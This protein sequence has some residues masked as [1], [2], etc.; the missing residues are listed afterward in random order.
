MRQKTDS[1]DPFPGDGEMSR[2]M[3]AHDWSATP[4]GPVASWPQSLKIAVCILLNSRYAMWLGWGPEFTFFY[5]DAYARMTL[6]A[7]HP[8]ALGRPAREVWPEIW[9]DVGPRAESVVRTG[10]A[11]WDER[12]LLFLE[13]RGFPEETY[14]TFSY[15]RVPDDC[16]GVGG[17]L[18]V[19]TEDTERTIGERR[20]RTLREL[21][22]RTTEEARSV[23]DACQ[24]AA[25]ILADNPH[26]LPFIL[27][28][29]IDADTRTARLAGVTGLP[30]R[31]AAAPPAVD[32]TAAEGPDAG[33]PLRAVLETGRAEVLTH[34]GRWLGPPPVGVYPELPH[35]AA[36]LP[37]RK[38]GQDRLA[39]FVVAG[40]SPRRPFD[41]DYQGFFDLLAGHIAT[42]VANARAYEEER[43]RAEALAELDRAKTAFFSNVS[44]EFRTPL[45][46]LLGPVEDALAEPD[47]SLSPVHR[48]LLEIA[49]R[50]GL[51]LKRL[52]N[53]LLDFSR[54][55]AGRVRA[56]FE[57]TDLAA[58]TADLAS[59]FRSACERAGLG[60]VVDCP[61]LPGPVFVDRQMWEN[62]VLNLLSNAFKFTF[63]GEIAVSLR[64]AGGATE[65]RVRD[66]G[67][68]IPPAEMPRLFERFHRVENARG[69]THEGSGIGLALVHELVKLHG[70]SITA[71]SEVGRGT[72]FLVS[73]PLG[74]EHLP[75]ERVGSGRGPAPTA[76]GASLFV[77]EA[78]RWLPHDEA[79]GASAE[80]PTDPDDLSALL[81]PAGQAASDRPRVLVADDNAD[82]RRYV[83][84]LLAGAY[85][86]EAVPDGAAA[87]EA[88][89]RRTPDLIVSDVMMPRLDGFGLLQALRA[90]PHTAGV[91][92]ILL[93]ARAGEESRVEG[94]Q[95]GADDYLVKPFSARELLA[96]VSAHLQMA[97]LRRETSESLREANRRK[98]EFLAMLAHELRNPL[99]PIRNSLEILKMPRLDGAAA[100][101]IREMMERQ[102]HHLVRLV[103]DL[104]DVSRVMRGKVDLRTEPVE[105][106]SVVARAV[107][108]AQ[109]L[110]EARGHELTIGLADESLPLEADPVRLAQVV[111]NL[112]TNAAKYTESHGRISLTARREGDQAVLRVRDT[113]IGIPADMLPRVF[114]LFVQVDHAT[115]KAQGGLGVGLTLVKSLAE[116]H[117]GTVEAHSPG[118]GEGS[119]FVVRLPLSARRQEPPGK[120]EDAGQPQP[121]SPSGRRLLVVDDNRDAAESLALL[122]R[123][124]GHEVRVAHDGPAALEMVSSHRPEMV[125]LDIG[126]PGMD[127]YE[128]ARRLQHMP[129]MR[130]VRLAALT[131]WGQEDDRR[132]TAQAGFDHHLVKPV[133]PKVLE[134]LLATLKRARD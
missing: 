32:L 29:L 49:R 64:Q 38:S 28:Y 97:R 37:L 118:P 134:E 121:E 3:R 73:I 82:M 67:T 102:V 100:E 83:V 74:S 60:L 14:H 48:E 23:E 10:Q 86:V 106:A 130:G 58:F 4:L 25:R 57:P 123:L 109:P 103:D 131:G 65:L 107:E 115:T 84:R 19:V 6:G 45:T 7:K 33:W 92:V 21:A 59:N 62:V 40:V 68:G 87:L 93:S 12:L 31:S 20:L 5:N 113:G 116:M 78:L 17:M 54:I 44:H 94:M 72:T 125:F 124:Q 11:T 35:T 50:N 111:G 76:A 51:R 15:S 133:E 1:I 52:V 129:G 91:P 8:R 132:R 13:R 55:E 41:D 88:V 24:T 101:R 114:D 122:L 126:M 2:R 71:G 117:G 39:G 61:P 98:D 81:L 105:L 89:R 90:D 95:A 77:E 66:T 16:G 27:L 128:V 120:K 112:L 26:D 104:L 70:G 9:G 80:L 96:R 75:R 36:V 99:A 47:G 119:E 22:A 53:T 127:G 43:K 30:P 56:L 42:A 34:V 110:I 85:A 108:T 46:L 79:D 18:C 63:E 69:R